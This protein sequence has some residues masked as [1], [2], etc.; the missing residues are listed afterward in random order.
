MKGEN[1]III[2]IN[3]EKASD[4]IQYF[5]MMTLKLVTGGN[6]INLIMVFRKLNSLYH[7]QWLKHES[8]SP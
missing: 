5:F 3:D 8:L 7:A 2:S 6:F 4:Q 1:H